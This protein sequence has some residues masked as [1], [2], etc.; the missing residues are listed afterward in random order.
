MVVW[1]GQLFGFSAFFSV[2]S[3]DIQLPLQAVGGNEAHVI[4]CH[5]AKKYDLYKVTKV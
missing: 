3:P 2:I 4:A 1:Q 5:G